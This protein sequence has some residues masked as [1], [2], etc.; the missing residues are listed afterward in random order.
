M[1]GLL[2]RSFVSALFQLLVSRFTLERKL[3]IDER[4]ES[5]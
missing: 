4:L 5:W 2:E 1:L 3:R